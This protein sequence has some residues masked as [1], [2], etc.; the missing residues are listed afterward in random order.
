MLVDGGVSHALRKR[1]QPGDYR[2]QE[3]WG[4][5][6]ERVE[7][8]REPGRARDARVRSA[9]RAARCTPR[10]DIVSI[11]GQW[12]VMEVE[13]TEPACGSTSRPDTTQRLAA[14]IGERSAQVRRSPA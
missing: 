9:A 14:A 7:P 4:G 2:V 11:G 8:S 3:E 10:I 13:V 1:P 6:T 12:H 5:T